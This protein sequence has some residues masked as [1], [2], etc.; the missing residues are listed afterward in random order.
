[1]FGGAARPWRGKKSFRVD[2]IKCG[3]AVERKGRLCRSE[4]ELPVDAVWAIQWNES[5]V[6]DVFAL[7]PDLNDLPNP[8]GGIPILLPCPIDGD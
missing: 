5:L 1:M 8:E 4:A 2:E 7:E 3:R 6:R